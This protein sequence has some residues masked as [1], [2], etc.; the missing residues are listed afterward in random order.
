MRPPDE[1]LVIV[2]GLDNRPNLTPFPNHQFFPIAPILE[3][4]QRLFSY[5]ASNY[6]NKCEDVQ[7]YIC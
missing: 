4:N 2:I 3:C 6:N 7:V 1:P 5:L